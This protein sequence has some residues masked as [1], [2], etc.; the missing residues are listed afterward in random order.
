M[1]KFY[2]LPM[3]MVALLMQCGTFAGNPKN[4]DDDPQVPPGET[5]KA[6]GVSFPLIELDLGSL[7]TE[8]A[9][10][11]EEAAFL[12]NANKGMPLA[13]HYA[14][15]IHKVIRHINRFISSIN[16]NK[17]TSR[18]RHRS[19]GP[20]KLYQASLEVAEDGSLE[21]VLCEAQKVL[22]EL[23]WNESKHEMSV[24][25]DFS[26]SNKAA[27]KTELLSQVS[28]Q[29][30]PGEDQKIEIRNIGKP[31]KQAKEIGEAQKYVFEYIRAQL[32]AEDQR[33]YLT[34]VSSWTQD[35]DEAFVPLTYMVLETDSSKENGEF[36]AFN[37]YQ[38]DLCPQA[39][40]SAFQT[41]F[42]EGLSAQ[43]D[44]PGCFGRSFAD[45]TP[46]TNEGLE[47]AW[48]RLGPYGE[49]SAADVREKLTFKRQ[50]RCQLD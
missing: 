24:I 35:L 40:R 38:P 5:I 4:A 3:I 30:V 16:E 18:G 48:K 1:I 20:E 2:S 32:M 50:D 45:P 14:N 42:N 17:L 47:E 41:A 27:E 33:R 28:V 29:F 10:E 23:T 9:E 31:W 43:N 12:R 26:V 21:L 22:L 36:L 6:D 46:Y 19:V 15:S 7:A 39:K 49:V 13:N 11:T 25:R 37:A 8:D 34:G 44:F